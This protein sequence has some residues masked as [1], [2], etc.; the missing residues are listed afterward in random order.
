MTVNIFSVDFADVWHPWLRTFF[1]FFLLW[2]RLERGLSDAAAEADSQWNTEEGKQQSKPLQESD[3]GGRCWTRR[4]CVW[5]NPPW[6]RWRYLRHLQIGS[7]IRGQWLSC[8][9]PML[10]LEFVWWTWQKREP[11]IF[12]QD[13]T[14]SVCALWSLH[15]PCWPLWQKRSPCPLQALLVC[16]TCSCIKPP[17]LL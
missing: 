9:C 6:R 17:E 2:R 5:K 16:W 3:S 11:L 7:G 14:D 15:T 4:R 13:Q 10:G 1:F 12:P 8:R